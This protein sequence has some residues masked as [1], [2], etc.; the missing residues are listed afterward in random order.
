MIQIS[1]LSSPQHILIISLNL[2]KSLIHVVLF[3]TL[4]R[5]S[6]HALGEI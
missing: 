5:V 4:S 3:T 2:L 6:I 1:K